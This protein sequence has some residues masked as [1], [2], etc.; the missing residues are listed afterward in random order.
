MR[1]VI[2][3]QGAQ[4]ESRFRGI[5]RYTL[6]FAQAIVRN[7]GEHEVLLALSGFFPETIEPIR[8]AFDGLLPQENIRVWYGPGPVRNHESANTLRREVAELIREAFLASLLPD[9]VHV[10]SLFEGYGDNAV[11]SI[12]LFDQFTPVSV[13]LYDLIPLLNPD[14]YLKPNPNYHAYYKRKVDH[15]ARASLMLA[16]SEFSRQE[17]LEHFDIVPEQIVNVSTATDDRFCQLV[18]SEFD[19]A[20]LKAKFNITRSF[21]L[22]TGGIDERKNLPRLLQAY[23]CLSP[24]LRE[25]Q[26]LVL[27]GKISEEGLD[28]LRNQ[29]NQVGITSAELV[30]TGYVSDEEL[31]LL[32]NLCKLFVFP[33]WHEGFGLPALEAM[34]CG[35]PVIGANASS[36]PEVIGLTEALFDPLDV[37]AIAAKLGQALGD[38]NFS[39]KLRVHGLS[40][41]KRFSWDS[42]ARQ[43]IVAFE[44]THYK[45]RNLV[46]LNV[47]EREIIQRLLR[48]VTK[49][50]GIF[51]VTQNEIAGIAALIAR[52]HPEPA[53][54]R[55]IFVDV[56]ELVQKDA[57]TGI[58]RVTRAILAELHS[59]PP[60]GYVVQAVYSVA[61]GMDY[62]VATAF[63]N[64][65]YGIDSLDGC[66]EIIEP[67]PG[68]V[69]LGLDLQQE[70]VVECRSY[71]RFLR[72]QGVR[73]FFVV[74]DLLPI[75]LPNAFPSG[76][77]QLHTQW[78]EV[79][80]EADGAVCISKA[81]ADELR[82]WLDSRPQA[83][84]RPL[85][86]HWFHLGSDVENSVPTI[87]CP[88]NSAEVLRLLGSM[89]TFLMLGTI[90][91][92]KGYSQVLRAFECL[93]ASGQNVGL[94]IVGKC[95]WGVEKVV[96]SIRNHEELQRRLFWLEGIS[97]EFLEKVFDASACLLAASEG[98]GFGLPL[99]E[100]ARHGLPIVA[101]DLPVFREVAGSNAFYFSAAS[102]EEL[103]ASLMKWLGMRASGSIP[104][105]D[106]IRC[107]TWAQS[108]DEL[109]DAIIGSR[110]YSP[111]H[112][113]M[114]WGEIEQHSNSS[115]YGDRQLRVLQLCPYP[116]RKPRHGGQLRSV[117]IRKQFSNAGFEVRTI[118]FFQAEAYEKSELD[119]WDIE[120]PADSVYRLYHG[121]HIP[122]L[123]DFLMAS[124]SVNDDHAFKKVTAAIDRDVDV[125]VIEQPWFYSLAKRLQSESALCSQSVL[126]FSSQNIEAPMKR[127]IL[128]TSID[129]TVLDVAIEDI[130][131]LERKA[132]TS[133]DLTI[134]V[135]AEDAKI[136][137]TY[138]AE[139][140]LLSPNGIMPWTVNSERVEYWRSVLPTVPWPIFIASA[141]P[142]NY[143]GFLEMLGNSLA[144][145]PPGSRLVVAGGV[146]THL[147]D[148]LSKSQ[149]GVLNIS[150]LQVLGVLD[151]VDLCAVKSLA[152]VFV[153]P[154]AAGGGSNIKTAEALYS[155]K[156][157]V[158]TSTA[159][160]GFDEY[161]NLPGLWVA[162]SPKEFQSAL[163]SVLG[164]G[165]GVEIDQKTHHS[166]RQQ[167]TWAVSL[168]AI[169][170]A[171]L[172]ILAVRRGLNE[173]MA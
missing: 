34:V 88:D 115:Q 89:P 68:D 131:A 11:T 122:A 78:L 114:K 27:A 126:V 79:V 98:E 132:A 32:Y 150:R 37:S 97:D 120:F 75:T 130:S 127:K 24:S 73:V 42:C 67:Q 123:S 169:P 157:V 23:A 13:S 159:L 60:E 72:H 117:A 39:E 143:Q 80:A 121:E 43:A 36:L 7:R 38:E 151:E 170:E 4:T 113:D 102:P 9:I 65:L 64:K 105:S 118:G 12:G 110:R 148:A 26:Q 58:Q 153:L 45:A 41:A 93:W 96:D 155:G 167:L 142:P 168:E 140:V 125:I 52:N 57:K 31:V 103:S 5:G 83:A 116:I 86:V 18:L 20:A 54:E 44:R 165:H 146:G 173:H 8:A 66:D 134:A 70:I 53:R 82:I 156:S 139:N 164:V 15:L 28:N 152:H 109:L 51:D 92:R 90:E 162:D 137:R 135:T 106:G 40:Q 87:G 160:R 104:L 35:A 48:A 49:V 149:W 147:L 74:Y 14:H 112:G 71:Y 55:R 46:S 56:S 84:F 19:S 17:G 107:L 119:K 101:R 136:L 81:V 29:A 30:F 141:H 63:M 138:G 2:D 145:I 124:Y 95:G 59:T 99:V 33:S 129:R 100:A 47:S 108:A 6:S 128:E 21:V 85:S 144:C 1:I 3:M 154:I 158:C 163:R 111:V 171:V 94:A 50:N 22:Y 91:P 76:T 133:A 77:K 62:R 10:S 172:Q 69:F 166:L 25:S 16:I 61:G 161:R